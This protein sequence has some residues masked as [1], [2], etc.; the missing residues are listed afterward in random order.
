MDQDTIYEK[1]FSWLEFPN[2]FNI[3]S[4]KRQSSEDRDSV[5]LD[6]T[7]VLMSKTEDFLNSAETTACE[8]EK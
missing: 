6:D 8:A 2:D 4:N 7:S 1:L 5:I 3:S